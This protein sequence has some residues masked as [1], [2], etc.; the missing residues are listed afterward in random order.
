MLPGGMYVLGIFVVSKED[1]LNP[2]ASKFRTILSTIQ[3]TLAI[4]PFIYGNPETPEK[5]V[6]NYCTATDSFNCKSYNVV[7]SAVKPAEIKFQPKVMKWLTLECKYDL[8]QTFPL[9][10]GK[11]DWTLKRHLQVL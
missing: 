11:I 2:F 9:F 4:N 8:D 5:L 1:L 10:E 7:T 6:L 3:K